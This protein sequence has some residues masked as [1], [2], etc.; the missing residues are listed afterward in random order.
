[1]RNPIFT[2]TTLMPRALPSM[3][4]L[5]AVLLWPLTAGAFSGPTADLQLLQTTAER[6]VRQEIA[7]GEGAPIVR[8][9]N[10]DARL[11]L[12]QCDRPLSA[13]IA[14]DGQLRAHTTVAVRC[15]GTVHWT[16]Y[17]SVTIDSEFTVL[18]A[19]HALARDAELTTAD[20]ELV[21]RHLPGLSTD[22]VTQPSTIVGQRLR[23]SLAGG[24]ALGMD[25]LT[26]SNAIHR[27]Q[28]VTLIAGS[29]GFQVRMSAVALSDG[30]IADRI[31]VQNLSSQRVV[32]GIVRS[33][34][35]VEV[36]L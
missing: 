23:K 34:S 29:A 20:F 2:Y 35:E 17:M 7:P 24:D 3:F 5:L 12:A 22:Y 36:P 4:A 32:E 27:G 31:R 13:A 1:M 18:V 28:Q 9:Q 26:P 21:Q 15:E 33:G 30:R 19:R 8:A 10:L 14:G 25:A 16:I 11:R 6:A